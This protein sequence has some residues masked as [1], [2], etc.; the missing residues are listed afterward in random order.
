MVGDAN[1]SIQQI[2]Y[3][4]MNLHHFVIRPDIKD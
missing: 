3:F 1:N 4:I 2:E